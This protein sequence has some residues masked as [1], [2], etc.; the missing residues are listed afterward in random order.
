[1][2]GPAT[3]LTPQRDFLASAARW[4]KFG[5][6][7]RRALRI[8]ALGVGAIAILFLF[9]VAV[10]APLLTRHDPNFQDYNAI[11]AQPA[12]THV[13]GT[14][15]LGRDILARLLFGARISLSVGLGAVALALLVGIAMGL[16]AGYFGGWFDDVLMRVVDAMFAFPEIL[17][18]LAL[19]AALQPSLQNTILAIGFGSTPGFARLLRGQVLSVREAEYVTAARA[20]GA[21]HARLMLRH[22]LPN[23]I[24]PLIVLASQS[25][26]GAILIESTLSFLGVGVPPPAPSWGSMLQTGFQFLQLAP[27]LSF[28]PG[29]AIFVAVL[30]FNLFGDGVRDSF[31]PRMHR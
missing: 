1:M 23:S 7:A 13:L 4:G 24:V 21:S 22:V 2:N 10:F 8:P 25:I 18:M 30:A 3:T 14:D 20:L 15:N 27:W 16:V 19:A 28:F 26:G 11:L 29:I 12:G 5:R 6:T 17:L 9:A 31:D